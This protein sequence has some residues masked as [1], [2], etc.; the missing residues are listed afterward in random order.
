MTNDDR[1]IDL[2]KKLRDM[3]Q[4]LLEEGALRED[5]STIH[6][7][8]ILNLLSALIL[9]EDDMILFNELCSM[10]SAK[11]ILDSMSGFSNTSEIAENIRKR[12]SKTGDVVA[13]KPKKIRKPR[14]PR[15]DSSTPE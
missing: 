3:G 12:L 6:T 14:K 4:A 13:E 1:R 9:A 15:D 11:K 2:S 10:F 7:G 8:T 5:V